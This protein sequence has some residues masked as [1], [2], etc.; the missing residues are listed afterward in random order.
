[1]MTFPPQIT[2]VGPT[3]LTC[4][5]NFCFWSWGCEQHDRSNLWP[6]IMLLLL[7]IISS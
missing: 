6:L 7:G 1:M 4:L 5:A 2:V 3:G